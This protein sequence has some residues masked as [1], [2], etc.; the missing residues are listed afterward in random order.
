MKC[1][2]AIRQLTYGTV[3]DALDEYLQMGHATSRQSLE[4]FCKAPEVP[5][6]TNDVTYPWGYY[7]CDRIYPE[8]VPFVKSVTNL[9]D[10][11]HKRLRY[12]AMHEGARKDVERAFGALKKQ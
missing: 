3:P 5:F 4:H 9:S 10:D 1:T 7:L 11:D 2:S 6:V 8:W 12:K